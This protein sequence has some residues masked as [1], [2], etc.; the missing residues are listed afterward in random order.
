M[1]QVDAISLSSHAVSNEFDIKPG[2]VAKQVILFSGNLG[3]EFP[4]EKRIRKYS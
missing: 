2:G 4:H 3:G 1:F